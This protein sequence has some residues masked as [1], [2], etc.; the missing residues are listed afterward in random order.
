MRYTL[1]TTLVV[2]ALGATTALGEEARRLKEIRYPSA[3][4]NTPQ[5]AMFYAPDTT[6]P[7]PLLVMLHTWSHNYTALSNYPYVQFVEQGVNDTVPRLKG[8]STWP[9]RVKVRTK[10]QTGENIASRLCSEGL[11]HFGLV[12]T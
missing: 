8:V 1:L 6:N 11:L 7:V 12:K 2:A 5:P 10:S 9:E 3:A 4:D